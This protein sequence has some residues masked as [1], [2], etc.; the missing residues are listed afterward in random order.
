MPVSS[1]QNTSP[2]GTAELPA[3][4]SRPSAPKRFAPG[5]GTPGYYHKVPVGTNQN[6]KYP[7]YLKNGATPTQEDKLKTSPYWRDLTQL[8]SQAIQKYPEWK[9]SQRKI[10]ITGNFMEWLNNLG[11]NTRE[12]DIIKKILSDFYE[13]LN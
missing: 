1:H 9:K 11:A 6:T 4:F 13:E 10:Q 3:H 8:A 7:H 12:A 2:G 5:V